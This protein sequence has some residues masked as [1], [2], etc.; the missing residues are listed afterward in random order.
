MAYLIITFVTLVFAYGNYHAIQT[1]NILA[2]THFNEKRFLYTKGSP[3]SG[4]TKMSVGEKKAREA[5]FDSLF[6]FVNALKTEALLKEEKNK[7]ILIK[8]NL[9][10]EG[11]VHRISYFF[12]LY[13]IG[14]FNE[15]VSLVKAKLEGVSNE[16]NTS[17]NYDQL[18]IIANASQTLEAAI[19]KLK[20]IEL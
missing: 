11:L 12:S 17:D 1:S 14:E 13:T 8:L 16:L 4:E 18:K 5:I 9:I 15:Q 6:S 2:I 20:L 3:S 19:E 7:I 10:E